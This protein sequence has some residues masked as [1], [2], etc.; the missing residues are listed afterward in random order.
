MLCD[1]LM[2]NNPKRRQELNLDTAKTES[3]EWT[4][5]QIPEEPAYSPIQRMNSLNSP[6]PTAALSRACAKSCLDL[7]ES[8]VS[9]SESEH[10]SV[11]QDNDTIQITSD[12]EC[13]MSPNPKRIGHDAP[14]DEPEVA[15]NAGEPVLVVPPNPIPKPVE[16]SPEAVLPNVE[17]PIHPLPSE[18][19]RKPDVPEEAGE[20]LLEQVA[21]ETERLQEEL[22]SEGEEARAGATY[23][24]P[25]QI[26]Y[27]YYIL[28]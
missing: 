6:E 3:M 24:V 8:I 5:S 18:P 26:L 20:S 19:G 23:K 22:G 28:A 2:C 15:R 21:E 11:F 14:N 16:P 4:D 9:D 17:V 27:I 12:D 7:V 13:V 25:W 10:E 1:R